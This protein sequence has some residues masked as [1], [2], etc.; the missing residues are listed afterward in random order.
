[1]KSKEKKSDFRSS[2]FD[3]AIHSS[4]LRTW[5]RRPTPSEAR[6]HAQ[7][8]FKNILNIL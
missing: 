4:R 2:F 8:K 5:R 3:Y 6:G 1:M 7:I